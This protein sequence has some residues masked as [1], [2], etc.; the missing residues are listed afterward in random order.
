MVG[1]G[2]L[3]RSW[4][5]QVLILLLSSSGVSAGFIQTFSNGSNEDTR[6]RVASLLV[7]W[8]NP[9]ELDLTSGL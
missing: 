4:L 3:I 1:H 7:V 5:L 2:F 6:K 8:M 9:H